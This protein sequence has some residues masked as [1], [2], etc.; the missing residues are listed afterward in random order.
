DSIEGYGTG[1]SSGS[2]TFR[3]NL[4]INYGVTARI[5]ANLGV[6]YQNGS[7]AEGADTRFNGGVAS[8]GENVFHV[9]AEVRYAITS[10]LAVNAGYSHTELDRGS[11]SAIASQL[12]SY[13]R[14]RHF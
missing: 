5:S 10:S 11:K 4:L 12:L 14:N 1:A 6:S 9:S 7:G 8:G 3:T 2:E 13:T